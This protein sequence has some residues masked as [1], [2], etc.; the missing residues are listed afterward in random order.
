M[1]NRAILISNQPSRCSS[2]IKRSFTSSLPCFKELPQHVR[3]DGSRLE[4][5]CPESPSSRSVITSRIQVIYM[6]KVRS[7]R[8]HPRNAAATPIAVRVA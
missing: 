8:P 1:S 4:K 6:N 7:S 2:A 3:Y 5:I